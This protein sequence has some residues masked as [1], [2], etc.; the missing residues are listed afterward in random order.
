MTWDTLL[1]EILSLT[2]VEITPVQS[3]MGK[4]IVVALWARDSRG[5]LIRMTYQVVEESKGD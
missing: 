1:A 4:P 3:R 5:R 2:S